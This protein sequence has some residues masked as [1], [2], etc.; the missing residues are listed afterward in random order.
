MYVNFISLNLTINVLWY[1]SKESI[2]F[3]CVYIRFIEN[4]ISH[5][6]IIDVLMN[7]TKISSNF[8]YRDGIYQ[9]KFSK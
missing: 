9:H 2:F 3:V 4:I 7:E 5:K 1:N 8:R 6:N